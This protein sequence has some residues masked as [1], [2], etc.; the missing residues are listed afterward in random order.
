MNQEDLLSLTPQVA[1]LIMMMTEMMETQQAMKKCKTHPHITIQGLKDG[2]LAIHLNL[3][4]QNVLPRS[5]G[6]RS[7]KFEK[8]GPSTR[9]VQEME[10]QLAQPLST[11]TPRSKGKKVF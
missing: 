8:E 2:T 5:S 10:T 4:H 3:A 6:P 9:D 11:V 7:R 1:A